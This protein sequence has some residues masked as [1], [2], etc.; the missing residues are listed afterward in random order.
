MCPCFVHGSAEMAGAKGE[1]YGGVRQQSGNVGWIVPCG[2]F[3]GFPLLVSRSSCSSWRLEM[4][5][6]SICSTLSPQREGSWWPLPISGWCLVSCSHLAGGSVVSCSPMRTPLPLG[7]WCSPGLLGSSSGTH[8]GQGCSL[9]YHHSEVAW[10]GV[11][12]DCSGCGAVCLGELPPWQEQQRWVPAD[13]VLQEC[14]S[15]H[16]LSRLG[17]NAQS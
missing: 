17:A 7:C 13:P 1:K 11:F 3:L 9:G 5:W 15:A 8:P 4:E 16:K 6:S 14:Q 12:W 2:V 10:V